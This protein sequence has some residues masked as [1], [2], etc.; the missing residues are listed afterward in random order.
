MAKRSLGDQGHYRKGLEN[1]EVP[2]VY[3]IFLF[4]SVR[5]WTHGIGFQ[6]LRHGV[7][8]RAHHSAWGNRIPLM[9]PACL[10]TSREGEHLAPYFLSDPMTFLF[11]EHL[12][13]FSFNFSKIEFRVASKSLCLSLSSVWI[14]GVYHHT[15]LTKFFL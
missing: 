2:D 12:F 11:E 10:P 15:L 14:T 9:V 6:T 1:L 5:W 4:K 3:C 13:D 8:Q 7:E